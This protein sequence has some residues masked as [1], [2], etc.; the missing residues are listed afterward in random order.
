MKAV[1]AIAGYSRRL[2]LDPVIAGIAIFFA[3][4]MLIRLFGT[5][6]FSVDDTEAAVHIQ[7]FQLY[8]SLRNPPLFNWLFFGLAELTGLNVFTIQLVKTVLLIGAGVFLYHAARPLFR[9]RS[10]LHAAIIGYGATV[11]YGWDIFQQFSHTVPLIFAL[12]FTLW[13][14]MQVLRRGQAVDYAFLGVGLGLGILSKYLFVLYFVALLIAALRRSAYRPAILSGRLLLTLAAAL[15][16]V[17]PLLIGLWADRDALFGT[18]GGRVA[19]GGH[20]PGLESFGLL[21]LLTAEFWLPFA[22]IL[23]I[24]HARWPASLQEAIAVAP[25]EGDE[26]FYPLLRDATVIMT[27]AM[28]ASF[29]LFG[30][31]IE[32]GR[33]LVAILSLL[34]LATFAAIDRWAPFPETAING[35]WRGAMI[36]MAII[37]VFRFLSFLFVSPPFCI[38]RCVVFVDYRPV[39]E[40]LGTDDG[41]QTVI[42][43]DHVHIASNLLRQVPNAKVVM[44]VYTAGSDLD[45]APPAGRNCYF[46]WFQK[47]RSAEEVPLEQALHRSLRRQPLAE[48]LAAIGP[49]ESVKVDWQTKVLP[50]WGPDTIVGIAKI[51]SAQRICD[52]GRIPGLSAPPSNNSKQ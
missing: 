25:R 10:A 44:D 49:I 8:Y 13:A 31:R 50:D 4:H 17:S 43:S 12:A 14:L 1:E 21:L 26:N 16:V 52:G 19:S 37:A 35:F 23:W 38:P 30:T 33:Y 46:V 32:G 20:G 15:V 2:G 11:F 7:V 24:A 29:F 45:I 22:A 36:L 51:D 18:L 3:L 34:P 5:S 48:E 27:V 28:F 42:M 41:K 6:N 9:H 39:V 47:Y 40:R